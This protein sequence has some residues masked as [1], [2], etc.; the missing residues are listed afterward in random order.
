LL[1]G[2]FASRWHF[3]VRPGTYSIREVVQDGSSGDVAALNGSVE[4]PELK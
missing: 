2:G 3:K 4:I 1:A